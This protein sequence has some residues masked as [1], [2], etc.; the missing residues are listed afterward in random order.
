MVKLIYFAIPDCF[1]YHSNEISWNHA[2]SFQ[3]LGF[4]FTVPCAYY[5]ISSAEYEPRFASESIV[6]ILYIFMSFYA[7]IS[8]FHLLS[9]CQHWS[10]LH[11]NKH[12]NGYLATTILEG[13]FISNQSALV[14]LHRDLYRKH[15]YMF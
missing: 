1:N 9:L 6:Y 10:F 4:Y 12:Q 15:C 11:S 13:S 7:Y 2:L 14:T 8:H 3:Y 5:C